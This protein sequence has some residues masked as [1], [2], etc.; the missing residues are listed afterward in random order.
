[1]RHRHGKS[2]QFELFG[3]S[4]QTRPLTAPEWQNL[5]TQTRQKVTDLMVRLLVEHRLEQRTT[6]ADVSSNLAQT[7]ENGDV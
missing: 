5:P 3:L 6:P 7:G 2:G 1:M 4:D